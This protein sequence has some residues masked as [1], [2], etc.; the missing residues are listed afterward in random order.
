MSNQ[1]VRLSARLSKI[2]PSATL[3]V[4]SALAELRRQGK[5]VVDF[6]TGEPDFDTPEHI[7]AA[8]SQALDAGKTKYTP[9]GGTLEL[10][11]AVV[12]KLARDNGLAYAPTEIIAS[13]GGKHSLL[14]AFLALFQEGDEVLVPAPFWVSYVDMLALADATAVVV[15][16]LEQDGFRVTPA[17][18]EAAIGP[19]TRAIVLNSPANPT[20]S[21]YDDEELRALGAVCLRHGLIVISDDVYERLTYDGFI[22]RHLLSVCPELRPYTVVISSC[23]K[24]YAM[25]GWRLGYAA[26]PKHVIDAMAT[27]QG[28]STSNPSSITQAAAVEALSGP[29]ECVAHMVAEFAKRRA[30]VLERLRAIPDVTVATPR[31]AFYVFPTIGALLGRRLGGRTLASASDLAKYLLTEADVAVVAGEDFGAPQNIRISYATS[32]PLLETGLDRLARGLAT[33]AAAV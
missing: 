24:T 5:D 16:S 13:C 10:K 23:S 1:P 18:L 32:M 8:A 33:V 17:A 2:K 7:K 4:T 9:V 19:R 22:Q 11:E 28:Q 31:G 29:Q 15:P 3:A 20:G 27:L 26:G 12:T 21:A 6:G 30:Y 14:N 25:T